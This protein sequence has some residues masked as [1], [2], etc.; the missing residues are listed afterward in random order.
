MNL[1]AVDAYA[2]VGNARSVGFGENAGKRK[3]R[4]SVLLDRVGYGGLFDAM[5]V[6]VIGGVDFALGVIDCGLVQLFGTATG[7]AL[8]LF[9]TQACRVENV[10]FTLEHGIAGDFGQG[11]VVRNLCRNHVGIFLVLGGIAGCLLDGIFFGAGDRIL[12]KRVGNE[13]GNLGLLQGIDPAESDLNGVNRARACKHVALACG[14]ENAVNV[15]RIDAQYRNYVVVVT[16]TKKSELGFAPNRGRVVLVEEQRDFGTRVAGAHGN[17]KQAERLL[18]FTLHVFVHVPDALVGA[19]IAR[20]R[21]GA[22]GRIWK[23]EPAA[24]RG[25]R[26]FLNEVLANTAGDYVG[27]QMR[28]AHVQN[29]NLPAVFE[30]E[31]IHLVKEGVERGVALGEFDYVLCRVDKVVARNVDGKTAGSCRHVFCKSGKRE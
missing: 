5:F 4:T 23:H 24:G 6:G 25:A 19:G 11:N 15:G 10:A 28:T 29:A 2:R 9:A 8:G 22:G 27:L 20:R 16:V 18:D 3:A 7:F 31:R 14:I 12:E 13:L 21:V 1:C 30:H 26:V 17:A